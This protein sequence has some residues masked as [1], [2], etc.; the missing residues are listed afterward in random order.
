[1]EEEKKHLQQHKDIMQKS[2]RREERRQRRREK[3]RIR[4]MKK[5]TKREQIW[6]EKLLPNWKESM[7]SDKKV[8]SLWWKGLS[9]RLRGR[10]W[11]RSFP[12]ADYVNRYPVTEDE[13]QLFCKRAE[14]LVASSASP[15]SA[16]QLGPIFPTLHLFQQGAPLESSLRKLIHASISFNQYFPFVSIFNIVLISVLM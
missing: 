15:I 14:T 1:M 2:M 13:Y 9:S 5:E 3:E 6:E 8:V 7:L 10:I 16:A 11:M 12:M 4:L